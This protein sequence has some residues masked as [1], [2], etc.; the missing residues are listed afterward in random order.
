MI[1]IIVNSR[2]KKSLIELNKIERVLQEKKLTYKVLKTSKNKNANSLMNEVRGNELIV[3]GGDGTINEVINNYRGKEIIYLAYGSGNDLAR[4]IRFKKDVEISKLLES[5]RFIEYDVGVVN[6]RK[7]CSGF[8]IGFNAD[9]IKSANSSKLKKYFGKYIYLLK[10]II[11]I[12]MLKKYKA[13]IS[14]NDGEIMTDRLYLLNAMVQPYEG[15]GIKFAP[16][17]TGHGGKLHVMIMENISLATFVY[18]YLCLLLKKHNKLKQV[19]Q[20]TTDRLTIKT[21]QKYFQID[22]ELINNT[23][24]LNVSCISKFYKLKRMERNE[25]KL[26]KSK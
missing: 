16:D 3:I 2:S 14:W 23:G 7:F 25:K 17:A 5:K 26:K 1:E 20:I 22:G 12:L 24:Q 15:G 19:K 21:N 10:G 18:N 6:D 11:G 9:I 4:S 8:D 13:E